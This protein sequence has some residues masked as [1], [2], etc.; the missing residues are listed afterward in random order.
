M[1]Q[2]GC[3]RS[4][5]SKVKGSVI[6][7]K[8]FWPLVGKVRM[9]L[10]ISKFGV[11][12]NERC[13]ST[14][15]TR[16]LTDLNKDI[17]CNQEWYSFNGWKTLHLR[18][19]HKILSSCGHPYW[20]VNTCDISFKKVISKAFCAGQCMYKALS[21]FKLYVFITY[22]LKFTILFPAILS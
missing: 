10:R 12:I 14:I 22:F 16:N 5:V 20:T 17:V 15:C 11:Y 7:T 3:P 8:H 4:K 13:E 1:I 9:C 6:E 19:T 2:T 18:I 21:L